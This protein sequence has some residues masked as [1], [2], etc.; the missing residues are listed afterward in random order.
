[1]S[2]PEANGLAIGLDGGGTKTVAWLGRFSKNG[3]LMEVLGRGRSGP[4]NMLA[5]G[6]ELAASNILS[7]VEDAF[8]K[9]GIQREQVD[10]ACFCLA[11]AGG[12]AEQ[13]RISRWVRDNQLAADCCVIHDGEALL[14]EA[15]LD[16]GIALICGTGSFAWGRLKSGKEVRCG[17]WGYLIDDAGSGYWIGMQAI[18]AVVRAAD[19]RGPATSL[20]EAILGELM[21]RDV[22]DLKQV[23]YS[24]AH[25]KA[26]VAHLSKLVFSTCET[27][28]TA[29]E[30]IKAAVNELT[31]L[32]T[33]IAVRLEFCSPA[34]PNNPPSSGKYGLAIGGGVILSQ[35]QFR[36]DILQNI[37]NAGTQ[38][39]SITLVDQP[40]SGA[41]KLAFNRRDGVGGYQRSSHSPT[42]NT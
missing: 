24:Q 36:T 21:L 30:I 39:S 27:C 11:G 18:R 40:A 13:D 3:S 15:D 10:N 32:V 35:Q 37:E 7:A 31:A 14:S 17:G 41:L 4:S 22:A 8:T 25:G 6:F 20:T 1:M 34:L 33:S 19:G 29:S 26:Q 2:M 28:E 12:R 23:V 16:D 5:V 9:A 38:L 42:E